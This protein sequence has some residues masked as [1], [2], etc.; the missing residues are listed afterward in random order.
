MIKINQSIQISM[1]IQFKKR[2]VFTALFLIVKKKLQMIFISN[3]NTK[4]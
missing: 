4:L 2:A 3:K 1:E